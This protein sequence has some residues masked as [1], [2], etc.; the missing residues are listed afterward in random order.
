MCGLCGSF[1]Q[2][3]VVLSKRDRTQRARVLEGLI[4]ANQARGTDSAGVAAINYDGA[5]DVLK[6]ATHPWRFVQRDDVQSLLRTDAPLMIGHTRMTSMGGDIT[7]ENAHP[8]VEGNV[9]GAHNGIIN[10]YMQLDKTVRVDSQAVFRLLDQ[11][12]EAHDYVFPKVS[13][14]CA[15]SWWDGR[16]ADALYLVAHNN[17]LSAAFVPRIKTIFWSSLSEHLEAVLRTA[18][19]T[20]VHFMN[21]KQDTIYRIPGEDVYEW[22]EEQVSFGTYSHYGSQIR[23]YDHGG[24]GWT[25]E[26]ERAWMM[27][28]QSAPKVNVG[29]RDALPTTLPMTPEEEARYENYWDRMMAE[30]LANGNEDEDGAPRSV[31]ERLHAL[32]EGEYEKV[33][34]E[35]FEV[36]DLDG[37]LDC[38]YCEKPLGEKGVWD[39]GLQMMLC[40][41]CQKWWDDFGHYSN[42]ITTKED[43]SKKYPLVVQ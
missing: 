2:Q 40:R 26:E 38:M 31:T 30:D 18:Y 41:Y 23:V 15:L 25:D 17:P 29:S 28:E 14:S 22:Q 39:N 5:Y 21:V 27:G 13:G 8:F 6:V 9:I 36:D 11:H 19:G 42:P 32:T 37:T 43:A 24:Y 33:Q 16:E 4:L 35:R 3:G 12:P 20:N 10:N 34:T 7:D 1:T